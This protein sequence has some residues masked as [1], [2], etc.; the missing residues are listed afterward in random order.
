MLVCCNLYGLLYFI[1]ALNQHWGGEEG[2]AKSCDVGKLGKL[3]QVWVWLVFFWCVFIFFFFVIF[4]ALSKTPQKSKLFYI[5]VDA[6]LL[7]RS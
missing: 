1:F 3:L 4:S 7:Q 2:A 5:R 6:N